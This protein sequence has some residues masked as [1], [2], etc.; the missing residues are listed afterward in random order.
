[1]LLHSV[2]FFCKKEDNFV[3]KKDFFSNSAQIEQGRF[4][5]WWLCLFAG[6]RTLLVILTFEIYKLILYLSINCY[7]FAEADV[8]HSPHLASDQLEEEDARPVERPEQVR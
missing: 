7:P 6:N 5:L 4:R 3:L 8:A 2:H 1:M